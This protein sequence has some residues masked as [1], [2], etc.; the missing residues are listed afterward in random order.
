[1]IDYEKQYHF[2]MLLKSLNGAEH[3]IRNFCF[4]NNYCS[5]KLLNIGISDN[6]A[7][8]TV[9]QKKQKLCCSVDK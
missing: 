1:M 4:H 2:G 6:L 9:L 8:T 5:A 3:N 7:V